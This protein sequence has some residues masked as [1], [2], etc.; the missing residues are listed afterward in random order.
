[1][2]SFW[3][4]FLNEVE[5]KLFTFKISKQQQVEY[6]TSLNE[7]LFYVQN[8]VLIVSYLFHK[9]KFKWGI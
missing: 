8:S 1:M 4:Y 9:N 3:E 7:T 2:S 5:K 6:E